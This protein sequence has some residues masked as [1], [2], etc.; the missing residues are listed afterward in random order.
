[1]KTLPPGALELL[2]KV[3]LK[4]KIKL[5]DVVG[6]T[7]WVSYTRGRNMLRLCL[8]QGL[9]HVVHDPATGRSFVTREKPQEPSLF[10]ALAEKGIV[11]K[12]T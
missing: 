10:D 4:G 7:H 9:L 12:F 11:A 6:L 8:D 2:E 3:P 5:A 1:M